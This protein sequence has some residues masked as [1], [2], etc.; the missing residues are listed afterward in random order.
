MKPTLKYRLAR[1]SGPQIAERFGLQYDG[2]MSPVPHGGLF[3]RI[4]PTSVGDGYVEAVRLMDVE[5]AMCLDKLTINLPD[6]WEDL[7]SLVQ[8]ADIPSY[9]KACDIAP[10]N[11][12]MYILCALVWA[13]SGYG[14]Y[15]VD[16]DLFVQTEPDGRTDHIVGCV[17]MTENQLLNLAMEWAGVRR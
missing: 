7:F 1:L 9:D 11:P 4:T 15:D 2:D 17:R 3:Y 10:N 6:T 8:F 5:G 16:S 14:M 13:A 12:P